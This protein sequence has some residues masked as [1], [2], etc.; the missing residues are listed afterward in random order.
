MDEMDVGQL[1]VRSRNRYRELWESVDP[2]FCRT[3]IKLVL[4]IRDEPPHVVEIYAI[5]P[6]GIHRAGQ[7]IEFSRG[8]PEDPAGPHRIWR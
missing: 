8:D 5:G 1:S 7:A 2:Y 3:P 6:T 4:P